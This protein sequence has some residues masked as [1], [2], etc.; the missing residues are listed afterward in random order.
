MNRD[1]NPFIL[2]GNIPDKYFCDR[3][4]ESLRLKN[5]IKG[6]S[7]DILLM[8]ERRIGKTSLITHCF[9]DKKIKDTFY[10]FYFDI[11][12]T[13]SFQEFI[14]ELNKEVFDRL[15]TKGEKMLQALLQ[16]VKSINPK[17][18]IDTMTSMPTLALEIGNIT[19]PERTLNDILTFL[20]NADKPCIVAIDEFQRIAR[21]NDKNIESLLRGKIQHLKNTRFIFAGSE[22]HLLTQM[23]SSFSRPFYNSA[24]TISL[25]RIEREKYTRFAQNLFN[26]AGKEIETET[27]NRLYD[28]FDGNTYCMQKMLHIAFD[29]T[30]NKCTT[31]LLNEVLDTIIKDN[32]HYYRESLS[33]L[34][35]RQ[36]TLLYA[37]AIEGVASKITSGEFITK[38]SLQSASSVQ[39]ALRVL[40]EN[41]WVSVREKEYYISDKFMSIFLKRI[42]G[43]EATI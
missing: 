29:L 11:L 43:Y 37:I 8:S 24:I 23:F 13:S 12:H 26:D 31:A 33:R 41:D 9:E 6:G 1:F 3:E 20:E 38:H 15:A 16:S 40:T 28:F 2:I 25:E 18:S 5:E 10:T 35:L 17:F 30:E 19:S 14:Y 34:A 27:I 42:S 32:E 36:K 39:A 22:R 21:Y 4:Q 7:A